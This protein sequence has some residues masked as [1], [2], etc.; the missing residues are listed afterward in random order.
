MGNK[1]K[2]IVSNLLTA[3]A[4]INFTFSNVGTLTHANRK[5]RKCSTNRTQVKL[6]S[7]SPTVEREVSVDSQPTGTTK[8]TDLDVKVDDSLAVGK[9]DEMSSI[10]LFDRQRHDFKGDELRKLASKILGSMGEKRSNSYNKWCLSALMRIYQNEKNV[11]SDIVS[12]YKKIG[13]DKEKSDSDAIL[14]NRAI[15]LLLKEPFPT[16]NQE[17]IKIAEQIKDDYIHILKTENFKGERFSKYPDHYKLNIIRSL[18]LCS[19]SGKFLDPKILNECYNAI[20]INLLKGDSIN[21]KKMLL[22]YASFEYDAKKSIEIIKSLILN[23]DPFEQAVAGKKSEVLK[24]ALL[25]L[26]K[27]PHGDGTD[28]IAALD[29]IIGNMGNTNRYKVAA[30]SNDPIKREAVLQLGK[31]PH[32]DGTNQ[33]AALYALCDYLTRD[34]YRLNVE[35]NADDESHVMYYYKVLRNGGNLGEDIIRTLIN[36]ANSIKDKE[37]K[38]KLRGRLNIAFIIYSEQRYKELSRAKVNFR[39][40]HKYENIIVRHSGFLSPKL[41]VTLSSLK[42]VIQ[43]TRR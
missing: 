40:I 12:A 25:Q 27:I 34:N 38:N 29:A 42:E 32:G 16:K 18:F 22:V 8:K 24:K 28:Q 7:K 3:C 39:L 43:S 9:F 36:A 5:K 6:D 41:K 17:V 35:R 1:F 4:L 19:K 2:K 11:E 14:L 31:I 13:V 30:E 20:D 37:R 21:S 10:K 15:N 23:G 33:L 26:A